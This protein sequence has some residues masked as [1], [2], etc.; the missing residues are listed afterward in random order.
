MFER[1]TERAR[2]GLARVC[3]PALRGAEP[4]DRVQLVQRRHV[5]VLEREVDVD[6]L[7]RPAR[8]AGVEPRFEV[9]DGAERVLV[10]DGRPVVARR[11]QPEQAVVV[12]GHRVGAESELVQQITHRVSSSAMAQATTQV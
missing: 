12:D 8:D 6:D 9:D 2:R 11:R 10:H 7:V 5:F 1:F 4:G 3:A